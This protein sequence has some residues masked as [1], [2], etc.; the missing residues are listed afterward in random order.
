MS[1]KNRSSTT[2]MPPGAFRLTLASLV[3]IHHLTRLSIG[4]AAVNV[5]FVLSGYWVSMMWRDR[6]RHT[7]G[8]LV[9]YAV[10]RA[11]RLLPV[12]L[13]SV[14]IT[15]IGYRIL[16]RSLVDLAEYDGPTHFLFSNAFILGYQ[17]LR[18]R[19]VT[20][21]WSLDVEVQFYIIL[22]V[23]LII[24]QRAGT[25]CFLIASIVLTIAANVFM[26]EIG[27]SA[28]FGFFALGMAASSQKPKLDEQAAVV[29]ALLSLT[30]MAALATSPW[31][32]ALLGGT[33][34]TPLFIYNPAVNVGLALLWTPYALC[35]VTRRSAKADK[36][37]ADLSYIVYL[38]H[39]IGVVALADL[40]PTGARR[41]IWTAVMIAGTFGASILIRYGF[42]LPINQARARWVRRREKSRESIPQ[43][44]QEIA[45]P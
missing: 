42:D 17:S 7:H 33:H 16:D 30:F 15:A 19:L 34:R 12:F 45:A 36:L 40:A 41:L 35:T 5:F 39:W 11:W 32:G 18:E 28:Y 10:S 31:R 6:Y 21:A 38:L 24:L 29:V 43:I 2:I 8:P 1:M 14:A 20:P 25:L 23:V 44:R 3:F 27:L 26:G 22:P 4:S 9:T 13:I 37:C